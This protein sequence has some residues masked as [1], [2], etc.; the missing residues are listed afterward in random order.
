MTDRG[1]DAGVSA[2]EEEVIAVLKNHFAARGVE[3]RR[4]FHEEGVTSI[5]EL[6]YEAYVLGANLDPDQSDFSFS[7]PLSAKSAS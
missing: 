2:L 3:Y 4:D 1:F 7:T 6:C 5:R